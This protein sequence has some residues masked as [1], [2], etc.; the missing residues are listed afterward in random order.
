MHFE[1]NDAFDHDEVMR[2]GLRLKFT[3]NDAL[4]E[5]LLATEDA[6]LEESRSITARAHAIR[7]RVMLCFD[8]Q[9]GQR[10]HRR[11]QLHC[12]MCQDGTAS[13]RR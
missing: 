12:D 4:K 10:V 5:A 2:K 7:R 3:Q 11:Q 1:E 13:G 9:D 6:R 8:A